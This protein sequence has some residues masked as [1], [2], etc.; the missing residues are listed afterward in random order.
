MQVVPMYTVS[1]LALESLA[2][3]G[4]ASARTASTDLGT[5]SARSRHDL[6]AISAQSPRDLVTGKKIDLL[7]IDPG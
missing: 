6:R 3:E 7:L 4:E 5:I 2:A 1:T